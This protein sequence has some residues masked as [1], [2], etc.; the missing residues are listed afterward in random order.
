MM[1]LLLPL[2]PLTNNS[3]LIPV[4]IKIITNIVIP[5]S[6]PLLVLF[7]NSLLIYSVFRL[8]KI[9]F[10][11][12]RFISFLLIVNII[13]YFFNYLTVYRWFLLDRDIF[14]NPLGE[15]AYQFG[16]RSPNF[17]LLYLVFYAPIT[18]V[19]MIVVSFFFIRWL[20]KKLFWISMKRNIISFIIAVILFPILGALVAESLGNLSS[21]LQYQYSKI[22]RD[23]CRPYPG[24]LTITLKDTM[25]LAEA[26]NFKNVLIDKYGDKINIRLLGTAT[27]GESTESYKP[28]SAIRYRVIV[29][30]G[31]ENQWIKELE[32]YENIQKV[33]QDK[34]GD[35]LRLP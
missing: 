19:I 14:S 28:S 18:Y 5:L 17:S 16:D 12:K 3:A 35:C 22:P 33:A 21:G 23:E 20:L 30:D 34:I 4:R 9:T 1:S 32:S 7:I 13:S 8:F 25:T 24:Y 26:E 10:S 31:E 6:H 11:W 29:P 15:L 2:V 27:S